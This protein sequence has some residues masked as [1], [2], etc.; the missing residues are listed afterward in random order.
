MDRFVW[1][2]G[3][4]EIHEALVIQQRGVRIYD[5]EEKVGRRR[6]RPGLA[7]GPRRAVGRPAGPRPRVGAARAAHW[8]RTGSDAGRRLPAGAHGGRPPGPP[9]IFPRT[10]QPARPGGA[11]AG[12]PALRRRAGVCPALVR[13]PPGSRPL[14]PGGRAVRPPG[15]AGAPA[16]PAERPAARFRGFLKRAKVFFKKEIYAR[17]GF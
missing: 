15:A 10:A 4:L 13:T 11:P 16:Q 12:S 2:S 7:L 9:E 1:T 14:P 5:G 6:G 17:K 8:L 3:L